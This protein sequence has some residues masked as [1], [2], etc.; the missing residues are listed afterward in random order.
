MGISFNCLVANDR[1][2]LLAALNE[3]S[4]NI[5]IPK[6]YKEEFLDKTNLPL[7]ENEEMAFEIGFSGGAGVFSSLIYFV[8]NLLSKDDHM[9]KKI[10]SKLRKYHIKKHMDDLLLS[11]RQLDY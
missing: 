7:T 8:M 3:K 10:D 6:M 2:E 4:A 5:L 1:E 9:Q 11:L